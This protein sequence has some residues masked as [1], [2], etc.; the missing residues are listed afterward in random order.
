MRSFSINQLQLI[1][2]L[3][4]CE[5]YEVVARSIQALQTPLFDGR[6]KSELFRVCLQGGQRFPFRG[7]RADQ[8]SKGRGADHLVH[9]VQR[10][11]IDTFAFS[12]W[13]SNSRFTPDRV[14]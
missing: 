7:R 3:R 2:Q 6:L 10:R 8:V 14:A 11:V 9:V 5:G 1:R 4:I 12:G 13:G